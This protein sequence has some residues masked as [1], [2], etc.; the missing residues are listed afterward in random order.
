[1]H[2]LQPGN[3][4]YNI[5][6]V[7]QLAGLLA[8]PALQRSLAALVSRHE[9]L[10]TTFPAPN[11]SPVQRVNPAPLVFDLPLTD[12]AHLPPA[13]QDAEV[14]R[15]AETEVRRQFDLA[16]G[17]LFSA[18]LL[19][20]APQEHIFLLNMHHI[21]SDG[22]SLRR[23]FRELSELYRGFVAKQSVSLPDLPWQYVDFALWQREWL[24]DD[25][26]I[27]A[28]QLAYWRQQLANLSTLQLP[29]DHP[30]PAQQTFQG[31]T[32]RFALPPERDSG[33][34]PLF[35][36][37]F[38]LQNETPLQD[39]DLPHLSATLLPVDS[40]VAQ[41][42]LSLELTEETE[43]LTAAMA[44]IELSIKPVHRSRDWANFAK[45]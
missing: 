32:Y 5:P 3:P 13:A 35:Q 23:F 27:R 11:H 6:F 31:H 25:S 28:Q 42:D 2:Q 44:A 20:L 4:A 30:R 21:I 40:G 33:R 24:A 29:T 18:A 39:L 22:W 38:S 1:L 43:G 15:L 12:L 17:P 19:R 9:S 34:Q 10:R 41:F 36:V 26:V 16:A 14:Y 45:I 7:I 37:M 8:P